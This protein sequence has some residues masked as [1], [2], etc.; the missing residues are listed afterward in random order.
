MVKHSS[1]GPAQAQESTVK[2]YRLRVRIKCR[3]SDQTLREA[4]FVYLQPQVEGMHPEAMNSLM[5]QRQKELIAAKVKEM[6]MARAAFL[7]E[8]ARLQKQAEEKTN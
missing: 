3:G 6:I 7:R 2:R 5:Q 1:A 8:R 4:S